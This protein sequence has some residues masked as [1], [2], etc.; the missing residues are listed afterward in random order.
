MTYLVAVRDRRR[1]RFQVISRRRLELLPLSEL[2][3][4]AFEND[5]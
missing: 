3:M 4:S 1:A 2:K 5:V